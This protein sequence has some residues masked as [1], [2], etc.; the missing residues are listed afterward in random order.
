MNFVLAYGSNMDPIQMRRRCPSAQRMDTVKIADWRLM[1]VGR[2]NYR[3]GPVASIGPSRGSVLHGVVWAVDDDD[4]SALDGYEGVPSC[5][6]R[7]ARFTYAGKELWAYRHVARSASVVTPHH[8]YLR[9]ILDGARD[10][11]I[12]RSIILRAA[13]LP[14]AWGM[15]APKRPAV[16]VHERA[17]DSGPRA[18]HRHPWKPWKDELDSYTSAR[19]AKSAEASAPAPKQSRLTL[20]PLPDKPHTTPA[21]YTEAGLASIIEQLKERGF[22]LASRTDRNGFDTAVR[23]P[24]DDG[25]WTPVWVRRA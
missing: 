7:R 2:S 6:D 19:A 15:P 21:R 1:F 4:L 8:E 11:D 25:A 22:V 18:T 14:D 20:V 9:H 10:A 5:Y 16:T 13:G 23:D 3:Q 12:D 24:D 17:F